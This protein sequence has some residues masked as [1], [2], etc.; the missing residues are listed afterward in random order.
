MLSGGS[1]PMT[2]RWSVHGLEN[3]PMIA[4]FGH[5][6]RLDRLL[7]KYYRQP[8]MPIRAVESGWTWARPPEGVQ[9]SARVEGTL[10]D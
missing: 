10:D 6:E 9:T 4:D 2:A 8:L 3:V 5:V 7:W 1:P